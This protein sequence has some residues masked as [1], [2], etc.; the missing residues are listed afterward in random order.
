MS[1]ANSLLFQRKSLE[2]RVEAKRPTAEVPAATGSLRLADSFGKAEDQ[3]GLDV[4]GCLWGFVYLFISFLH[5]EGG[6]L[7]CFSIDCRMRFFIK[8]RQILIPT[9]QANN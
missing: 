3:L 8:S 2:S 1:Y 6:E 9:T 7:C 4:I 5:F